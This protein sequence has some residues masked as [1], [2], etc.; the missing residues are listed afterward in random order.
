MGPVPLTQAHP[1]LA[2]RLRTNAPGTLMEP[3]QI[4]EWWLVVRLERYLPANFD[5]AMNN[6]MC[7]E[8]F[9]QWVLEE[10]TRRIAIYITPDS[11]ATPV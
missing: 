2:E 10:T 3:F 1:A 7:A 6:K 5:A 11:A 9:E 4:Q 8:L